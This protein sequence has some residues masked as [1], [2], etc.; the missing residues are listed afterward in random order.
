MKGTEC[1]KKKWSLGIHQKYSEGEQYG[2]GGVKNKKYDHTYAL[3]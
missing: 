1:R 3:E 2:D